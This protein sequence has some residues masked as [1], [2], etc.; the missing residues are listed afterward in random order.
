MPGIAVARVGSADRTFGQR[1]ALGLAAGDVE[2]GEAA[3]F[4]DL[5]DM[6]VIDDDHV[7]LAGQVLDREGFEILEA[8][9]V[10]LDRDAGHLS[11]G[12]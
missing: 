4:D 2:R 1:L 6:R 9:L 3:F 12:T 7:V 11:H 10:P 5:A 8:A